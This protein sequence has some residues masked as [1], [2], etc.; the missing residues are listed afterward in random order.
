MSALQ[1]G[2]SFEPRP[3]GT[4]R[5]CGGQLTGE[6]ACL[7]CGAVHGEGHRCPHCGV[8]AVRTTHPTLGQVCGVCGKPRLPGEPTPDKLAQEAL[9]LSSERQRQVSG[10]FGGLA[11]LAS[12]LAWPVTGLGL[13]LSNAGAP[14]SLLLLVLASLPALASIPLFSLRR[15]GQHRRDE[16]LGQARV[17]AATEWLKRRAAPATAPEIAAQLGLPLAELERSL[18][19]LAADPGLTVEVTD[20]GEL[21]YA[22]SARGKTEA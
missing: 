9:A 5:V 17:V 3:D 1:A 7:R 18:P 20:E 16:A 15:S 6:L 11:L 8:V 12:A 10:V 2:A 13:W 22:A 21:S 19:R 14:A 4:C